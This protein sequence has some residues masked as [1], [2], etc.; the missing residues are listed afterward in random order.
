MSSTRSATAGGVV[1]VAVYRVGDEW[2]GETWIATSERIPEVC[3]VGWTL[4]EAR[5]GWWGD[6][7]DQGEPEPKPEA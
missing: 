5:G 4:E 6:W 2:G 3:S 7:L 1:T